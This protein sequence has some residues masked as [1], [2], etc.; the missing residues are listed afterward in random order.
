MKGLSQKPKEGP[1]RRLDT[2]IPHGFSGHA[3]DYPSRG[4]DLL[5]K[6]IGQDEM[7]P[8]PGQQRQAYLF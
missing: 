5:L 4:R 7:K 3:V 1:G 2:H 8:G 6:Q